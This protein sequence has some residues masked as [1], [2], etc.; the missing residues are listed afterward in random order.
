M[1]GSA[2]AQNRASNELTL[3]GCSITNVDSGSGLAV[4]TRVSIEVHG[5]RVG[6]AGLVQRIRQLVRLARW[7]G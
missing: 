3:L 6:A 1:C 5:V 2:D 4:R 7:N